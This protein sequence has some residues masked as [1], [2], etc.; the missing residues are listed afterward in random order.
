MTQQTK[1]FA[2]GGGLDLITQVLLAKPGT[3]VAALNY[4]PDFNGYRRFAGFERYDGHPSPSNASYWQLSF[5]SGTATI[6]AGATVTGATSGATGKA[7]AAAVVTSGSYGGSNAAGYIGLGVVSG[8]F[9]DGENLQVG[10]VTKSVADGTAVEHASPDDDTATAWQ[11]QAIT[12]ARALIA[13]VPGSGVIRGVWSF[14]GV[15]YAFRDNVGATACVMWKSSAAGWAAVT[16]SKTLAFT[17]GGTTEIVE[18]NTITGATSGATAVVKRVVRTSGDWSAGTAAGYFVFDAQTG[19]FQAENVNVGASLNLATIAGNSAAIV[20]PAGGRYEFVT[21]NFYA[22]EALT[23]MYGCNGVGLAFEFDGTTFCP[24]TTDAADASRDKPKR[25]RIHNQALALGFTGGTVRLSVP[26]EPLNFLGSD[27]AVEFGAGDDISDIISVR[28]S[29]VIACTNSIHV[30]YGS[31]A[32]DYQLQ[33]LSE[34]A[35]AFSWTAQAFGSPVYMDNRGIRS[36]TATQSFGNFNTGTLSALVQPLIQRKIAAGITPV[37]SVR[38]RS[39]SLYRLFFS[40]NSALSVFLGRRDPEI[41]PIDLGLP[42]E[43]ICSVEDSDHIERVFFGSDDG[44]VYEMDKGTSFDGDELQYLLRIPYWH[45][46][47]PQVRKRFHKAE[48]QCES[49]PGTHLSVIADFDYGDPL[50]AGAPAAE[51]TLE[52]GGGQWDLSNWDE[53]YWSAP[54]EGTGQVY[55]DGVGRNVSLL[56]AGQSADEPPHLLQGLTWFHST[57]GLQR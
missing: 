1:Y 36:L 2:F 21:H 47:S 40:D 44:F 8:T 46:G 43:C 9:V 35:G 11:L 24:I 19:T 20:L 39:R 4:E 32:S 53:F 25:I 49:S 16:M 14:N 27:G 34:E 10:G 12:N 38:V 51:L 7:L 41:L 52:G 55:I 48:I 54:F 17:S 6:A 33:L 45:L 56:F 30:L 3:A 28:G 29:L 5:E 26:G 13:A 23:R 42:V 37:A 50:S 18:G 15:R 57:R 31:D 22:I